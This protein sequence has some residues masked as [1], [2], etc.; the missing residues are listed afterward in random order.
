MNTW[1][2]ALTVTA[3]VG[4]GL[5]GGVF[6]AFSGFVMPALT[7]LPTAAGVTAMQAINVTA[8]TPP[9]MTALFGTAVAA[10]AVPVV[11]WRVGADHPAQVLVW[12]AGGIYLLGVV[13]VTVGA[14]VPL[15]DQL[16]LTAPGA[17]ADGTWTR[18]VD[19]WTTYNHVRTAS[20]LAAAVTY[21]AALLRAPS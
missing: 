12:V 16:A 15:N 18:W 14:S 21:C 19:R 17:M 20:A 4:S 5:V 10:V 2:G 6:F 8:T 3:A 11:A 13:G 7:R 1:T 9:L